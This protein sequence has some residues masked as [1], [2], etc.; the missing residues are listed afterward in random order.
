MHESNG[1]NFAF[2]SGTRKRKDGLVTKQSAEALYE[3][4]AECDQKEPAEKPMG[5]IVIEIH[6]DSD[7]KCANGDTEV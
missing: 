5:R 4:Q 3:E 2:E 6:D 1:N 7:T